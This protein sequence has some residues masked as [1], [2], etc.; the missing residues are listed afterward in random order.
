MPTS[1]IDAC[2]PHFAT[3]SPALLAPND[4]TEG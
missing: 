4:S 2:R 3:P 1:L